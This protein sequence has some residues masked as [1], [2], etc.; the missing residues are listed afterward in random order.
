MPNQSQPVYAFRGIEPPANADKNTLWLSQSARHVQP[1]HT[2]YARTP[3]IGNFA[4]GT[5]QTSA[6]QE[7]SPWYNYLLG[8]WEMICN[9]SSSQSF[10]YSATANGPWSQPIKVLG[11]SSGGEASNAQQ[12]SVLIEGNTIFAYYYTS[13]SASILKMASAPMPALAGALPVFT[14]LGTI[15]DNQG[16]QLS[17]SSWIV[18]ANGVYHLFFPNNIQP[19]LAISTATDPTQFVA[20]PFK[21]ISNRFCNLNFNVGARFNSLFGRPQV[22][23]ENGQWTYTGHAGG[24]DSWACNIFRFTC[25]DTGLPI[26]WTPDPVRFLEQM[27]PVEVDQVA[28]FRMIRGPNDALYGFWSGCNNQTTKFQIMTAP[29]NEPLMTFDGYDWT[30]IITNGPNPQGGPQYINPD[31]L[32]GNQAISNMWDAVFRC[33]TV[34]LTG[35]FPA[36]A[37]H[38]HFLISN[39]PSLPAVTYRLIIA[40]VNATDIIQG[41]NRI[42]AI[43]ATTN[44]VTVTTENP[45]NLNTNDLITVTGNAPSTYN[46][47]GAAVLSIPTPNSFTYTAPSV[48]SLVNTVMGAYDVALRPFEKRAYRCRNSGLFLRD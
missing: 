39:V 6:T 20:T 48:G 47:T 9:I 45:H 1:P 26:N 11:S 35:T 40:P 32:T 28:D 21:K 14:V 25:N 30:P 44:T 2:A 23:Y 12:C 19:A 29:M 34:N 16:T 27:H 4:V 17:D 33:N 42:T 3:I 13:T 10:S 37:G 46:A 24:V 7:A 5:G 38:T 22:S 8:R 15:Y 43:S 18:K 31:T 36:A 41:G